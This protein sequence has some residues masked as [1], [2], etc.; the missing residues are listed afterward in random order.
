[1]FNIF[2]DRHTA[3]ASKPA[4]TLI[5]SDHEILRPKKKRRLPGSAFINPLFFFLSFHHIPQCFQFC[6]AE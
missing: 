1:M 6:L 5:S 3:F 2:V 4:P